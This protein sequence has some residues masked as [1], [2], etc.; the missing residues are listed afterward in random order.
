MDSAQSVQAHKSPGSR[1]G[2]SG[3]QE[4][5]GCTGPVRGHQYGAQPTPTFRTDL[6]AI[7]SLT[8]HPRGSYQQEKKATA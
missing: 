2:F 1:G 4:D 5:A 3:H 6:S 8:L 7:N